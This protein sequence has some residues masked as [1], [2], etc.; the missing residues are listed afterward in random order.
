MSVFWLAF[1]FFFSSPSAN[2][3]GRKKKPNSPAGG[4]GAPPKTPVM[5]RMKVD[6]PQPAVEFCERVGWGKKVSGGE[7]VEER[8]NAWSSAVRPFGKPEFL[9]RSNQFHAPESAARPMTTVRSSARTTTVRARL[10]CESSE[11][12]NARDEGRERGRGGGAD[13][14]ALPP[15]SSSSPLVRR[16]LRRASSFWRLLSSPSDALKRGAFRPFFPRNEH[17][18]IVPLALSQRRNKMALESARE[19]RLF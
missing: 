11:E 9:Q 1:F 3:E 10:A 8:A 17:S 2:L 4:E 18:S 16:G 15:A 19:T 13:R 7:R 6:L 12:G 5:R 14:A